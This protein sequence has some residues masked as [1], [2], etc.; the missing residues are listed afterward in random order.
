MGA[1]QDD[2][3]LYAPA[4]P[5]SGKA[6]GG[7]NGNEEETEEVAICVGLDGWHYSRE[8]LDGF[9][10]PGEAHYRRVGLR[11]SLYSLPFRQL[12]PPPASPA[13]PQ[14]SIGE[15]GSCNAP[16]QITLEFVT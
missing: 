12:H 15:I 3:S 16:C 1:R 2:S 10:D 13:T 7:G 8:A 6:F 9:E 14:P 5:A 4:A 11:L